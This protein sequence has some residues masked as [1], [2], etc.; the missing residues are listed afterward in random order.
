[1]SSTPTS[2]APS[3]ATTTSSPSNSSGNSGA[4]G[5]AVA[6]STSGATGS[7]TAASSPTANSPAQPAETSSPDDIEPDDDPPPAQGSNLAPPASSSGGVAGFFGAVVY[8]AT[9]AGQ[10][11]SAAALGVVQGAANTVN[12]VQDG[13]IGMANLP[14]VAYNNTVGY[15]P[16]APLVQYIP[17]PDWSNNLVTAEDPTQHAVSKFA[18]GTGVTM[19]VPGGQ[20]TAPTASLGK[21]SVLAQTTGGALATATPT[22]LAVGT[23]T[24]AVAAPGLAV[25]G[26]VAVGN[27]VQMAAAGMPG[28]Q[29]PTG[30]AGSASAGSFE[31][32]RSLEV[33]DPATGNTI[34]DIDSITD[35][36]RWEEK[37]ALFANNIESWISKH[38]T[39]KFNS[40]MEARKLL[41]GYENAP[42][43][44]KFSGKPVDQ[45]FQNAIV[46]AIES[47]RAANPGVDIRLEW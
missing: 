9:W 6:G 44:F 40:Y 22:V 13:L 45:A 33:T 38:I 11:G 36:V 34:T 31:G 32:S 29:T 24:V 5:K 43:G 21:V 39:S 27:V 47:L 2:A 19:L 7:S 25:A 14:G 3:G 41:P 23:R 26:E 12:G 15:I 42:I 20:F 28:G 18:G 8:A 1:M 35:G 37:S 46:E 10:V 30:A 17:S 4:S 16:G